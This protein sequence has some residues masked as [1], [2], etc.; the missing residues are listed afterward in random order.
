[1]SCAACV[2]H[3]EHAAGAVC[4]RENITVS[5]MTNS[6]TVIFDDDKNEEKLFSDLKRALRSAG[7]TLEREDGGRKNDSDS[8][9]KSS[10]RRL[11]ASA[12]ITAIL[13][14]VAMSH[15]V[16]LPV[17]EIFSNNEYLFGLLQLVLTLPVLIINR[18]FF[19]NGFAAL[20]RAAPNMDTLIAIGSGAS[21]LYGCFA[22]G[23]MIYGKATGNL[24]L[25]HEYFHSLYFESAAMILTLVTLGKTLEGKARA[26]AAGAITKLAAMLPDSASVLRDGEFCQIPISD[27]KVGDVLEIKVGETS[28]VDGEIIFGSGAI[29]ESAVSGESIPVE[30]TVGHKVRAVSILENGYLRIRAEQVGNDTSLAKII[31]LLE[32]AAASKAPLA[33]MAD[34]VSA[35]FVPAVLAISLLTAVLWI[36]LSG[37]IRSAFNCAVSV[38]VIS[39]PC[40]LGLATPTAIMVGTGRGAGLG[41]LIKSAEALENLHSVKFFL[42]DK[43]GTLT[44]GRPEVTDILVMDGERSEL[45]KTAFTV[46]SSSSHPLASAVCRIAEKEGCNSLDGIE[47]ISLETFTGKGVRARLGFGKE[48][49]ECLIG[50]TELLVE[51]NTKIECAQMEQIKA[52]QDRGRSIICVSLDGILLGILGVYDTPTEDSKEAVYELKKMGI[53]PIMVTGDNERAARAVADVCGIDQVRAGLLPEDKE[54]IIRE[55]SSK[56]VTVMVGDGVNDAPALASADIGIAVGAGTEIAIDSADVVLSGN[57]LCGAVTA[58]SLSKA[59]VKTIKENLFWALIYNAVCIPI[60]AGALSSVGVVLSPMVASAA[61]SLSSVC[62]VLNSLRLNYKKIYIKK[63]EESD[64]F[65]KTKTLCFTVDGMM[66]NNCKAHVEKALLSVKGVKSVD[67]VLDTKQVTVVAKDSVSSEAL[68]SAITAAGYKVI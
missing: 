12:I 42:T 58:I 14:V 35:I 17:G 41:V 68:A 19:K 48:E 62:V 37:D 46:E 33:R 57:S 64:M 65:G 3:V 54:K 67:A 15:M 5:L 13:M 59:T 61:M 52:L 8:E 47:M 66:C 20:F 30:K 11:V 39:C 60:A 49:K 1:M 51:N 53:E 31:R 32:D 28:P 23:A 4:G 50:N 7:Y 9:F 22:I 2:A 55:Y 16:G 26:N 34:R 38:L 40:A 25:I 45:L 43:T 6:L 18:K 29:N 21:V 56:G 27:I 10:L 63:L 44:G 24:P 36:I